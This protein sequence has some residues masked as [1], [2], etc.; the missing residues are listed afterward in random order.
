[1]VS[2]RDAVRRTQRQVDDTLDVDLPDGVDDVVGDVADEFLSALPEDV[3]MAIREAVDQTDNSLQDIIQDAEEAGQPIGEFVR[4]QFDQFLPD[5]EE[6]PTEG[7][8]ED[9]DG[10]SI[11]DL[12]GQAEPEVFDRTFLVEKEDAPASTGDPWPI[13]QPWQGL[14]RLAFT[15]NLNY[16]YDEANEEWVRQGPF[17]GGGGVTIEDDGTVLVDPA[18]GV[19]FGTGLD[20]TD[21]GDDTVT[22]DSTGSGGG[23]GMTQ[24]AT[25]TVS[26]NFSTFQRIPTGVTDIGIDAHAGA[27]VVS[28]T[29]TERSITIAQS[30]LAGGDAEVGVAPEFDVSTGQWDIFMDA[31]GFDG[32]T[33]VRWRLYDLS[34]A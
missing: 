12:V 20:V 32:Q 11:A 21:D 22:V 1:M 18:S 23:G 16:V 13:P 6:T 28:F 33:E 3:R 27:E 5:E 24:L 4:D 17:D 10:T 31:L 19:N 7:D 26:F 14:P 2:V 8:E 25:G 29:G 15:V 30:T 34:T 9:D